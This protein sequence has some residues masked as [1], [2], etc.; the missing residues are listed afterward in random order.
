MAVPS[1]VFQTPRMASELL[2][3]GV[4]EENANRQIN[5]EKVRDIL[6]NESNI[7]FVKGRLFIFN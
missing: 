1:P 7:D 3:I 5:A 2:G 6:I 4:N